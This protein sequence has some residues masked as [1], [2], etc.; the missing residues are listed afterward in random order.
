MSEPREEIEII[1]KGET[2]LV[3]PFLFKNRSEFI[4][5]VLGM[6]SKIKDLGGEA[7]IISAFVDASSDKMGKI[8]S[9]VLDKSTEW[10]QDIT[11]KNEVE[12][13]AAILEVNDLPFL[14][15]RMKELTASQQK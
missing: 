3:K 12:L 7:E 9:M 8:Y 6:F 15:S 2:F 11:L 13:I 4:K 1:I 10:I 5:T 14:L